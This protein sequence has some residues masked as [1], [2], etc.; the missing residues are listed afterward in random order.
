M[1][2]PTKAAMRSPR[3]TLPS[4]LIIIDNSEFVSAERWRAWRRCP[5]SPRRWAP[6]FPMPARDA[7]SP[8][9]RIPT[10][11][12]SARRR[13]FAASMAAAAGHAARPL[14]RLLGAA[15]STPASALV[16]GAC[17]TCRRRCSPPTASAPI[18]CSRPGAAQMLERQFA[19][20]DQL[21]AGAG[22]HRLDRARR[23]CTGCRCAARTQDMRRRDGVARRLAAGHPPARRNGDGFS[24]APGSGCATRAASRARISASMPAPTALRVKPDTTLVVAQIEAPSVSGAT[25]TLGDGAELERLADSIADDHRSE[26]CLPHRPARPSPSTPTT[27]TIVTAAGGER[28]LRHDAGSL[29]RQSAAHRGRLVLAQ[30]RLLRAWRSSPPAR[31]SARRPGSSCAGSGTETT[32]AAERC[33]WH[34]SSRRPRWRRSRRSRRRRAGDDLG[35]AV[36]RHHGRRRSTRPRCRRS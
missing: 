30:H 4:R 22:I 27:D 32:D 29:L 19:S 6:A 18:P 2:P 34:A 21:L 9:S 13:R 28:L 20:I 16:I 11:R 23:A 7:P 3:C 24:G 35:A 17:V 15:A 8:S 10:A 14:R 33:S 31:C 26:R 5:T 36:L 1:P 25:W 12:R